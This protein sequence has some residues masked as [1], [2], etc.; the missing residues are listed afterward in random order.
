MRGPAAPKEKFV[1]WPFIFGPS[2]SPARASHPVCV[3]HH[4]LIQSWHQGPHQ[5]PG[6]PG[7][8]PGP[9]PRARAKKTAKASA[10]SRARRTRALFPSAWGRG[11]VMALVTFTSD[12]V[13]RLRAMPEATRRAPAL[14]WQA[15]P[16][17]RSAQWLSTRKTAEGLC[18]CPR[19]WGAAVPA[20]P[21]LGPRKPGLLGPGPAGRRGP[22]ARGGRRSP[23]PGPRTPA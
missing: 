18:G 16:S 2:R 9:G 3:H 1:L 5:L 7:G 17:A 4:G 8:F 21:G 13:V 11:R 15:R 12:N 14:S 10:G 22:P 6:P 20:F 19:G 23:A